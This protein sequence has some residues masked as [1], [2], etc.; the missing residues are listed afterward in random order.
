M[1]DQDAELSRLLCRNRTLLYSVGSTG[2]LVCP[3][4]GAH[5]DVKT[6]RTGHSFVC[7]VGRMEWLLNKM[8]GTEE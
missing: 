4:C 5:M 7:D 8:F 3:L 6:M 2:Q 1:S